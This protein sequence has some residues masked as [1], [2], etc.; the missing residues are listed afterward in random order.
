MP[1]RGWKDIL[2]RTAHEVGDDDIISVARSIAFAGMLALFPGLAAFVSIYGLV[3][4]V[5]T[6]RDHLAGL[7]GIVPAEAMTLIGE[8]IVRIAAAEQA[9]LSFTF[10]GGLVLSLWSANAGMKALF[11]GLNIAYEEEEKRSFVQ[12]NLI[13]LAFTLG[14]LLLVVV[15]LAGVVAI[16]LLL[17]RFSLEGGLAA[18]ALLRWPALLVLVMAGLAML[19][20]YGPSREIA[21]WRWVTYGGG[22][23]ALLWLGGSALFSWYL[24]NVADYNAT[25]GSLGAVFGF[26]M[27]LWLSAVAVLLGAELNSEL[28]HQTARDSTTGAPKPMGQRG[29]T[30]ADTLGEPKVGSIL[31]AAIADRLS[32]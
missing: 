25:Y 21:Q 1:A 31:P 29:A 28:E 19:Y 22:A 27:W 24:G 18:L 6:A 2:W 5:A 8:Q 23:S 16:P 9:S 26:M 7:T 17:Q 3:A 14:A 20:R 13:S 32:G 15:S 12:L 4:D 11:R 10:V 30:M